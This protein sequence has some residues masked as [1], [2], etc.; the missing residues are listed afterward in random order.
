MLNVDEE[1][2]FAGV[3]LISSYKIPWSYT[4]VVFV[5]I[6]SH[7]KLRYCTTIGGSATL[8]LTCD[9]VV[10]VSFQ[11][12]QGGNDVSNFFCIEYI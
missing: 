5:L 8:V 3:S 1:L 9:V 12:F 4:V 2:A 10:S 7:T 11:L 6:F